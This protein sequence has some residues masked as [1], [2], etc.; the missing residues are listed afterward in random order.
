MKYCRKCASMKDYSEFYKDSSKPDGHH[1]LCKECKNENKNRYRASGGREKEKPGALRRMARVQEERLEQAAVRAHMRE[2]WPEE[3]EPVEAP[4][5]SNAMAID[6]ARHAFV[7]GY[8]ESRPRKRKILKTP[9]HDVSLY[10][11]DRDDV[12][13]V[14]DHIV[15]L[16]GVNFCGLDVARNLQIVPEWYNIKK[17]AK[18]ELGQGWGKQWSFEEVEPP[19]AIEYPERCELNAADRIRLRAKWR[20]GQPL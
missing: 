14:V 7:A 5:P 18:L 19:P 20:G 13:Y 1:P 4:W 12:K 16:K 15:P 6:N 11:S 9:M 10:C 17:G 2:V 3:I 8:G